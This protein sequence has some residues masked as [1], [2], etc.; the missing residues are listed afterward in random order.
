MGNI[1]W[2]AVAI[3]DNS[4]LVVTNVSYMRELYPNINSAAFVLECTKGGGRLTGSFVEYT[5][6]A[7]SYRGELF[8]LMAIVILVYQAL[9]KYSP[10]ALGP[11]TRWKAY[12]LIE[13]PP[14]VVTWTF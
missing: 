5:K 2:L 8:G 6:D 14:D 9:P 10:T 1:G 11:S 4:L 3:R 12:L 7:C 13:S